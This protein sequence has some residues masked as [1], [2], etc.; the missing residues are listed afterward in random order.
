MGS[1]IINISIGYRPGDP[2]DFTASHR[3][4][5]E[6]HSYEYR[7]VTESLLPDELPTWSK[8]P[9]ALEAVGHNHVMIVDTDAEILP[10]CPAFHEV[11]ERARPSQHIFATLGHSFRPN[12]GMIL[13]RAGTLSHLFLSRLIES[14]GE[15]MPPRDVCIPGGDNGH[16]IHML[17]ADP[18]KRMLGLLPTVWNNTQQPT[19]WDYIRHYTG[20]MRDRLFSEQSEAA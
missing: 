4:Y 13:L 10:D 8:H 20:P 9:A 18:W 6:R 11:I 17:R 3:A 5:A 2:L 1:V 16:F 12:A 15:V 14:R 7:Q 19:D